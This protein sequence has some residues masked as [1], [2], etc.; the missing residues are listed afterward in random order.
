MFRTS[1]RWYKYFLSECP[2]TKALDSKRSESATATFSVHSFTA[3][4][5][6][7]HNYTNR[8]L[9]ISN[10]RQ[11]ATPSTEACDEFFATELSQLNNT[12]PAREAALLACIHLLSYSQA[13]GQL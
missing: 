5:T 7:A 4:L 3:A 11:I 6:A 12:F 8:F 13:R 9:S 10:N 2:L 1:S